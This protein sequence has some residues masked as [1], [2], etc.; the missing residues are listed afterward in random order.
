MRTEF[1]KILALAEDAFLRLFSNV[2]RATESGLYI[3]VMVVIRTVA[4]HSVV[5]DF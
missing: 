3:K 5:K 1:V 2:E 4:D